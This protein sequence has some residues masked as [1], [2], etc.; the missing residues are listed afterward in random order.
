[1]ATHEI[2]SHQAI[3]TANNW[4]RGIKQYAKTRRRLE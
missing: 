2:R 3:S 4:E 1:L